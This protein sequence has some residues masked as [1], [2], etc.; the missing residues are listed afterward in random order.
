MILRDGR[1]FLAPAR[2]GGEE[3]DR[4]GLSTLTVL[5]VKRFA[6][7]R[8]PMVKSKPPR[9]ELARSN[10]L[11]LQTFGGSRRNLIVNDDPVM[12]GDVG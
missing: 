4:T 6:M 9:V 12:L 2:A 1:H 8:I 3:R 5:L 11:A 10:A 7:V